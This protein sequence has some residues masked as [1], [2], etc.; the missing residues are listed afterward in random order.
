MARFERSRERKSNRDS[1][2]R[3]SRRDSRGS[4]NFEDYVKDKKDSRG[5]R[6][7]EGSRGRR[8]SGRGSN[9][10]RRD[11]RDIEMTKVI[12]SSCGVE[13][14]VPFKPTTDKPVYCS[15]CFAKKGRSGSDR[16]SNR[17]LE[18][19]NEKIDKIMKALKIE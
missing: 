15:D 13:C 10:Y 1:R 4:R 18:I 2:D 9:N 11:R 7:F 8:D 17:D 16:R 5:R 19:I 14:E 3:S 6:S 12:C